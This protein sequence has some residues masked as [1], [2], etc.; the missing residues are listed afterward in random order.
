MKTPIFEIYSNSQKG[1]EDFSSTFSNYI[2]N[3][4]CFSLTGETD[5]EVN[6]ISER[7]NKGRLAKLYYKDYVHYITIS[8]ITAD[9]RNSSFQSV[10]TALGEFIRDKNPNKTIS[11]FII[12]SEKG[13]N[14]KYHQ[15]MYRLMATCKFHFI[16]GDE[17][18]IH[19]TAFNSVQDLILAKEAI[20]SKNK[21][22][23][24]SFV[25]IDEHNV[26]QVFAK[27]YGANKK[28]SVLLCLAIAY[29]TSSPLE[30]IQ[31][32]EGNLKTLPR[33]DLEIISSITKIKT[34]INNNALEKEEFT[35]NDSL[36]SKVYI[37]N[38]LD[39]FGPKKCAMC[40][41]D[42]PQIIQGAHIWPVSEI[43]KSGLSDEDKIYHATHIDN[44]LWLCEN[45]HRL[46]DSNIL[47]INDKGWVLRNKTCEENHIKYLSKTTLLR[48]MN[49]EYLNDGFLKYLAERNSLLNFN[50]YLKIE[51]A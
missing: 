16:N 43:K 19:P 2:L 45:H 47:I 24:S 42:I 17:I 51:T 10:P 35:K 4:I 27:T 21:S 40:D 46:F 22:N 23:N 48:E 6:F 29:I 28:E 8:P 50:D 49:G 5:F 11:Y 44:G 7:Y 15:F 33:K 26:T 20:R 12:E 1:V 30:L 14:T 32:S 18:G 34:I 13:I 31:I 39:K 3:E 9:G 25:T 36:R 37:Y 41:C 38:L